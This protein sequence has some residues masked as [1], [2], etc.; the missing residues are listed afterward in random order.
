MFSSHTESNLCLVSDYG[1]TLYYNSENIVFSNRERIFTCRS[2][3][4]LTKPECERRINT[5]FL[6]TGYQ[7]HQ[8]DKLYSDCSFVLSVIQEV[9]Q[10]YCSRKASLK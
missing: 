9:T 5:S 8:G 7:R 1:F 6:N 2:H 10:S 4:D 3:L